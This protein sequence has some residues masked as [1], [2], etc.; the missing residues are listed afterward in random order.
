MRARWKGES[1]HRAEQRRRGTGEGQRGRTGSPTHSLEQEAEPGLC[2]Q[3]RE[4]PGSGAERGCRSHIMGTMLG[5]EA[6][7]VECV[8]WGIRAD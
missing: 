4:T 5:A 3:P 8:V 6:G 1:E 2:I 7:G